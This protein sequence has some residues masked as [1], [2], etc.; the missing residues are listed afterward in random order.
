VEGNTRCRTSGFPCHAG[1]SPGSHKTGDAS[2]G[3]IRYGIDPDR[4]E[5]SNGENYASIQQ[6]WP[7]TKKRKKASAAG[8]SSS[9]AA[10]VWACSWRTSPPAGVGLARLAAG[11]RRCRSL[12]GKAFTGNGRSIHSRSRLSPSR[13]Q[14]ALTLGALRHTRWESDETT[15]CGNQT[16]RVWTS[17]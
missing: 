3:K 4:L 6:T 7:E 17:A 11:W 2:K 13:L 10:Q 15:R 14:D 5:G 12:G 9:A 16:N 8:G 1:G